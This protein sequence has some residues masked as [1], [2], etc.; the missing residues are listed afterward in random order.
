MNSGVHDARDLG[1]AFIQLFDENDLY[2]LENYA[3]DRRAVAVA[4]VQAH[5]DQHYN[6]LSTEIEEQRQ[7]R[8]ETYRSAANDPLIARQWVLQRAMLGERAGETA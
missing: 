5:T 4:S 1:K 2:A 3:T 8:N 6:E 7:A